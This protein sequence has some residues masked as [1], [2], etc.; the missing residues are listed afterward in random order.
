MNKKRKTAG[1]FLVTGAM[2]LSSWMAPMATVFAAEA[3]GTVTAD[4]LNVRSG[5]GTSYSRIGYVYEGNQVNVLEREDGWYVIEYNGGTG[6]VAEG[7]L[8]V[9]GEVGSSSSDTSVANQTGVVTADLLNV[10]SG[11]GTNYDRIDT[12]ANGK[13]VTLLGASNGWYQISYDGK[14]GYVSGTY[15][16]V[17]SS[18]GTTPDPTPTPTQKTGVVTADVLNVRSGPSTDY[19][20]IDAVYSGKQL[21]ITGEI[22]GWYQVSYDGKSGYVSGE[23]VAIK[24]NTPPADPG[25]DPDT[26]VANKTGIVSANALNVRSGPGTSYNKIDCIFAG[27]KVTL[28]SLSNGWYNISYDGKTGYVSAEYIDVS[29]TDPTPSGGGSTGDTKTGYVNASSLNVRTGPG[30]NFD[31]IGLLYS[32]DT[33][34]ITGETNGWYQID[35]RGQVGYVSG[36]YISVAGS[37]TGGGVDPNASTQAQ[38]LLEIARNEIGY[39]EGDNNYTKY[40][41]WYGSPNTEWC[42]MFVSWCANQAGIAT[43]IIPCHA[44]CG[45]GISWFKANGV[46]HDAYSGYNPQVG[47][48]IYWTYGHVGIVESVSD[49]QITTIEGNTTDAVRRRTYSINDSY[50]AGFASPQYQN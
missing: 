49:T 31:R 44:S 40:G 45:A 28:L 9:T 12:L 7:Y 16:Q 39:V 36:D 2:L 19:S 8:E 11:P 15:I 25:D 29:D 3:V 37:S 43:S 23:Y 22:N 17:E 46:W 42:A 26:S 10:R 13:K 50:F 35:Y 5:P 27:K 38:R 18:G 33:V 47:D 32:G 48:L 30:T 14:T 34:S 41:E 4:V 24:N 21:T 6:Y 20:K 1:A